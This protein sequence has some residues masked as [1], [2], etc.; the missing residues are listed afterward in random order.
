MSS[1]SQTPA[2]NTEKAEGTNN[3]EISPFQENIKKPTPDKQSKTPGLLAKA[4]GWAKGKQW[5]RVIQEQTVQIEKQQKEK[6]EAKE[7]GK[8][9]EEKKKRE[10]ENESLNE[11]TDSIHF[12]GTIDK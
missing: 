12:K 2:K 4:E 1:S 6:Y 8:K 7:R 3:D 9:I 10:E 5:Q 11:E